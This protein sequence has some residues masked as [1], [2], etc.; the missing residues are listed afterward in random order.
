[1]PSP[2]GTYG[3]DLV[4]EQ[5]TLVQ[6]IFEHDAPGRLLYLDTFSVA[7]TRADGHV[8]KKTKFMVTPEGNKVSYPVKDCLHY[9]LPGPVDIWNVLFTRLF[10]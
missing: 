4:E 1:M 7:N 3:W 10:L 5:N 2:N 9:C 6:S 8:V